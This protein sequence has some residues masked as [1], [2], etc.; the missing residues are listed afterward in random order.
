ME[1][2]TLFKDIEKLIETIDGEDFSEV[3]MLV[4]S[5]QS[6]NAVANEGSIR[7]LSDAIYSIQTALSSLHSISK[8]DATKKSVE[9]IQKNID[10]IFNTIQS[11]TQEQLNGYSNYVNEI[12]KSYQNKAMGTMSN[13]TPATV[14]MHNSK[15]LGKMKKS[16]Q[17]AYES[18][19]NGILLM[20]ESAWEQSMKALESVHSQPFTSESIKNSVNERTKTIAS[21]R[22]A[23]EKMINDYT[24]S[25]AFGLN[26]KDI[27]SQLL[28]KLNKIPGG[29]SRILNVSDP[30]GGLADE[31][32]NSLS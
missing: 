15:F 13:F 28:E 24:A 12:V 1:N 19:T 21:R 2:N 11:V 5:L 23:Y 27:G 26:S 6:L 29:S 4:N 32:F 3:G 7:G 9:G 18:L 17:Q 16:N 14:D 22:R 10:Q 30:F 20:Q 25:N 8:N 31:L